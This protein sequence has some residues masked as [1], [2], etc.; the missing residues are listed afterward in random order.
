MFLVQFIFMLN[1]DQIL[2]SQ[3][4]VKCIYEQI[5]YA[6]VYKCCKVIK[7]GALKIQRRNKNSAIFLSDK[8]NDIVRFLNAILYISLFEIDFVT[9]L[10]FCFLQSGCCC[11]TMASPR[12]FP[13]NLP[14]MN[15]FRFP[16]SVVCLNTSLIQNLMRPLLLKKVQYILT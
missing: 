11:L 10:Y 3:C 1:F 5:V 6:K 16:Y 12:R 14:C 4:L 15:C 2:L 8:N 13:P 7:V 9:K